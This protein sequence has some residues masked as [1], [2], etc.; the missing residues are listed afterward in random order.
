MYPQISNQKHLCTNEWT[1]HGTCCTYD[2]IVRYALQDKQKLDRYRSNMI[3]HMVSIANTFRKIPILESELSKR[4]LV[5]TQEYKAF[6]TSWNQIR[7]RHIEI[8]CWVKANILIHQRNLKTAYPP[9]KML[10]QHLFVQ[11]A[12]EDQ[13]CGSRASK[14]R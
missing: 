4:N 13:A 11:S 8:I 3:S 14:Q 6:Y 9:L 12:R 1:V 5:L 2:C 7:I 10:G